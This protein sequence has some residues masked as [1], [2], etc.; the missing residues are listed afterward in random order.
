MANVSFDCYKWVS[1]YVDLIGKLA[2]NNYN[3]RWMQV[4][5]RE[6]FKI[7]EKDIHAVP[8]K[9]GFNHYRSYGD[10]K[11]GTFTEK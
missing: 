4:V 8:A 5:N 7:V 3:E 10:G 11:P 9:L 1:S 2:K 6:V